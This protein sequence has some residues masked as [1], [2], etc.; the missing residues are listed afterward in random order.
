MR[1]AV[2]LAGLI[3]S[4]LLSLACL[5]AILVYFNPAYANSLIFLLFYLS[6]F[7]S[8]AGIFSLLGLLIRKISH[9]RVSASRSS[10]QLWDSFRQGVFLSIILTIVLILQSKRMVCWWNVLVLVGAI[11]LIEFWAMRR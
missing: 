4:I 3:I 7:I 1:M 5:T 6:L 2:F 8:S 10:R 11:G 9:R